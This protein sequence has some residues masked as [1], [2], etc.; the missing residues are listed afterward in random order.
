MHYDFEAAT[1]TPG[2]FFAFPIVRIIEDAASVSLIM[3]THLSNIN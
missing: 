3:I 1:F 2:A